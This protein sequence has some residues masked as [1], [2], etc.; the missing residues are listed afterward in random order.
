MATTNA[1]TTASETFGTT[2]PVTG[3]AP[4]AA[5][6][7]QP[8]QD[9]DG[10]SV[11][12]SAGAVNLS[13]AGTLQAYLY[14]ASVAVWARAEFLDLT[15]TAT[16]IAAQ[17][18]EGLDIVVARKGRVKWVPSGVT[19]ASGSGGVTVWQLGYIKGLKGQY[20]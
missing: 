19:F 12:V 2:S 8:I 5:T 9:L 13:G 16:G 6:D 4:S 7:G 17:A 11:I 20:T 15:V 1:G 18:F 10:V 3:S 14:D